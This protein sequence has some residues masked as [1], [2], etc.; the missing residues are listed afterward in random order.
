[1]SIFVIEIVNFI[2]ILQAPTYLDIVMN[3][4]AL[5]IIAE[6]DNAFFM[7]LGENSMKYIIQDPAFDSLYTITRTTSRLA[8]KND[9]NKLDDETVPP[10][11]KDEIDSISI[12]FSE[13]T[14]FHKLLRVIYKVARVFQI[15]VWFYFLPFIVVLGSYFV[16]YYFQRAG[17]QA[18]DFN[19]N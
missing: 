14:A 10:F 11:M 1:M 7:A 16:P 3:F 18:H 15:T 19:N 9:G 6:F 5:A 8:C 4:M 13:R 17:G 2:V 12:S